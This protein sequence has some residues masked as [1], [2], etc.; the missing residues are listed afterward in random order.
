MKI[1]NRLTIKHLTMNKKRTIVTIIGVILST[2][3]M[4]GI[5]L[6]F[7]SLRD[8]TIKTTMKNKGRQ[9]VTLHD[10][11]SE[12][13]EVLKNNIQIKDIYYS[14]LL[15]YSSLK[16]SKNIEKPY[17]LVNEG[18]QAFLE[19]LYLLDGRLPK[20][21]SEVV[22]SDHIRS[23]GGVSYKVGDTIN[24]K[25]GKRN[26]INEKDGEIVETMDP[27]IGYQ[28]GET[29]VEGDSITYKIVGIVERSHFESYISPGYMIYTKME[30]LPEKQTMSIYLVYNKVKD[31]YKRTEEFVKNLDIFGEEDV[32]KHISF[33]DSLLYSYGVSRYSNVLDSMT[34]IIIIILTLVSIGCIIVIY[35][36]FAI[37]VMERKKQ[38]GLFSSI[39]ATKKQLRHTVFFEAMIVGFIGIPLGV[40]GAIMG[41]G[42]VLHIVNSMLP[43]VF[44][45]P[46]ALSIYLNFVIIPVI[47]MILVI[48]FS[49]FIPALRASKITPIE[50]IRQNDDIKINRKKVKAPKW[51]RK[52]FGIEGEIAFKNIKRNKRKYRITIISLFISIVL[53]ISFSGLMNYGLQTS[54]IISQTP[55]YDMY[56]YTRDISL[57]EKQK[58]ERLVEELRSEEEVEKISVTQS[59]YVDSKIDKQNFTEDAILSKQQEG[60]E[61]QQ[62]TGILLVSVD[63]KTYQETLRKNHLKEERPL[64]LNQAFRTIYSN[65]SRKVKEFSILKEAPLHFELFDVQYDEKRSTAYKIQD[66]SD[67]VLVKEVPFGT[68]YIS[69]P[70]LI[71]VIVPDKVINEVSEK[72]QNP[73]THHIYIK[74][75]N[76]KNIDKRL[77]DIESSKEISNSHYTNVAEEMKLAKNMIFVM[78]LLL[79][80]FISLVSLIGVTSVFNTINTSIALRRKEFA[81]LRSVGLTPIGFNKILYFESIFFGLKS[82]LYALPVSLFITFLIGLQ[83]T[84]VVNTSLFMIPFKSIF[85]AIIGV[86]IIV[87]LTM[88]YASRKI[89]RENILESIR[90]E[91][92]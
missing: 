46:L 22:I 52:L 82:L 26:I 73:L 58:F 88:M 85:I 2:S 64:I 57:D 28:E 12:K 91:N 54:S 21:K 72:L 48:I 83:L 80:G 53:F 81:M 74:A 34:G 29:L 30:N 10:I 89:K 11:P 13:F 60:Y 27:E 7:A 35:N 20:D 63:E 66:I 49:A 4:V 8:N 32:N 50:A 56:F 42:V 36:S 24:L 15:G 78:K 43:N 79:Y 84:K 9:H 71:V 17:L 76:Y 5:G 16:N 25:L 55:S 90:E 31:I 45:F 18:S 70:D 65:N 75:S 38:F 47:F 69:S 23:N 6:L 19:E 33:N 62:Y 51:V 41:I 87:I 61:E 86:F 39:G 3:L 77:K 59:I 14:H 1:L 40:L 67:A 68:D 37:S 44:Q 92:I